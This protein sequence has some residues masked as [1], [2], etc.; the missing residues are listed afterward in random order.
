MEY[1]LDL[2]K[3]KTYIGDKVAYVPYGERYV[4][5]CKIIR[6]TPKCVVVE[7]DYNGT[8]NNYIK[9]FEQD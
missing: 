3:Q 2:I 7:G 1:R 8:V 9:I 5:K 6:F 4:F